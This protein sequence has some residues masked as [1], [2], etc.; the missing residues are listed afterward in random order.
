MV[1]HINC[2]LCEYIEI[3][4]LSLTASIG[5]SHYIFARRPECKNHDKVITCYFRLCIALS[6][7]HSLFLL[8]RRAS[9]GSTKLNE[10]I[11]GSIG[12]STVTNPVTATGS[13]PPPP[14]SLPQPPW[15][16]AHLNRETRTTRSS[17]EMLLG[18]RLPPKRNGSHKTPTPKRNGSHKTPTPK[19]Q[20]RQEMIYFEIH[21]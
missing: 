10:I 1:L 8:I 3:L 12:T 4:S 13:P 15:V 17:G 6:V 14:S 9:R 2:S 5:K 20:H 7:F 18:R 19:S 11:V 21:Q 16:A